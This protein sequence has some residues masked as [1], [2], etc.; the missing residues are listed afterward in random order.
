MEK[1]DLREPFVQLIIKS[2]G[3]TVVLIFFV[4]YAVELVVPGLGRPLFVPFGVA[5]FCG[6][7]GFLTESARK[8]YAFAILEA[9]VA[10][11]LFPLLAWVL[12]VLFH[13]PYQTREAD[14][15]ALIPQALAGISF[16]HFIRRR[17]EYG[18]NL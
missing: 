3:V 16:F 2:I 11:M 1:L 9:L 10:I 17:F 14:F 8:Q 5:L 12:L 18:L 7:L 13:I 6:T 15:V 4:R